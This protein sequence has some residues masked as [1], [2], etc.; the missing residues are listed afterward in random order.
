MNEW[1]LEGQLFRFYQLSSLLH[2]TIKESVYSYIFTIFPFSYMI[3]CKIVLV[4]NI[5]EILIN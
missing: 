3:Y 5:C 2:V 4:V 1:T